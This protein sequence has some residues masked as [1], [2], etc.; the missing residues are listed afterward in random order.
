VEIIVVP[1]VKKEEAEQAPHPVTEKLLELARRLNI[2]GLPPDLAANHDY[3]LHGL[4]KGIDQ[5]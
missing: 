5:K 1:Q 3:Y 4:P 2:R